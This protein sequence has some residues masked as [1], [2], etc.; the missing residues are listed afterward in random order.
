[1]RDKTNSRGDRKR[2]TRESKG[3]GVPTTRMA[4]DYRAPSN[5]LFPTSVQA[6]TKLPTGRPFLNKERVTPFYTADIAG[7][8]FPNGAP[9]PSFTVSDSRNNDMFIVQRPR[10]Y[11]ALPDT[12]ADSDRSN[13]ISQWIDYAVQQMYTGLRLD[14]RSNVGYSVKDL[15]EYLVQVISLYAYA[16]AAATHMMCFNMSDPRCP[17]LQAALCG[18]FGD[19]L[20]LGSNLT[21]QWSVQA[22]DVSHLPVWMR[23]IQESWSIAKLASDQLAT[24]PIPA[25]FK[26]YVDYLFGSVFIDEAVGG[27]YFKLDL[28]IDFSPFTWIAIGTEA[29]QLS[30]AQY[31]SEGATSERVWKAVSKIAT[32]LSGP[33]A[34][35]NTMVSDLRRLDGMVP[36]VIDIPADFGVLPNIVVNDE[37][38]FDTLDNACYLSLEGLFTTLS[39]AGV[40]VHPT[41]DMGEVRV[42]A[43]SSLDNPGTVAMVTSL[44]AV[45]NGAE[46][47]ALG[48]FS[49]PF[50]YAGT[51]YVRQQ[52]QQYGLSEHLVAYGE[53]YP[54]YLQVQQDYGTWYLKD[55]HVNDLSPFT[56]VELKPNV[57]KIYPGYAFTMDGLDPIRFARYGQ[58]EHHP[59]MQVFRQSRVAYPAAPG[60]DLIVVPRVDGGTALHLETL[61]VIKEGTRVSIAALNE[62][63]Y[64]AWASLLRL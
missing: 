26:Q 55:F 45:A 22:D 33:T 32:A 56:S 52:Y 37:L 60:K 41:V 47:G 29:E 39:E 2:N 27:Q 14:N 44:M 17:A 12:L 40:V 5:E 13:P 19:A 7:I 9:D 58:M 43:S 8:T 25:R 35:L 38:F 3:T 57:A 64:Y 31:F 51:V 20:T 23:N 10:F 54:A 61:K 36:C 16:R 21:T 30:I 46:G 11:L 15:R 49:T 53:G 59:T 18:P 42:D 62:I 6:N 28:S 1:M 63:Q 24:L 50:V 4:Y 34:T 48:A